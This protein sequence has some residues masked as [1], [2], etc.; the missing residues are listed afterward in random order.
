FLLDIFTDTTERAPTFMIPPFRK[1]DDKVSPLP[2][3]FVK[4]PLLS[5]EEVWAKDM[6]RKLRCLDWDSAL[7]REMG[8]PENIVRNPPAISASEMVKIRVGREDLEERYASGASAAVLIT[9]GE[10]VP[11][12]L[13]KAFEELSPRFRHH[14]HLS[15]GGSKGDLVVA[16][17]IPSSPFTLLGHMALKLV[18]NT[19]ST[20]T[21]VLLG[22]VAGNWMS[23]VDCT[24]KKLL[25][26]GTRLVCELAGLDYPTA[27]AM[28]FEALDEIGR[29]GVSKG[30][31][32]PSAVQVVLNKLKKK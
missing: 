26:R 23:W 4:N 18:L 24:N 13:E 25:D 3:A 16:C 12:A 5:T 9:V 32:K 1:C 19:I 30:F 7:L 29:K 27:C 21:M 31:E 14:T 6:K 2:W 22:R 28:I 10:N 8:A 11:P 17:D 20:G 15:I